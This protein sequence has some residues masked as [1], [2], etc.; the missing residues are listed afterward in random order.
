[1][2]SRPRLHGQSEGSLPLMPINRR[3]AE[4]TTSILPLAPSGC[5]SGCRV[6]LRTAW[7]SPSKRRPSWRRASRRPTTWHR[8]PRRGADARP[9]VLWPPPAGRCS[10]IAALAEV[11]TTAW[12]EDTLARVGQGAEPRLAPR[13]SQRNERLGASAPQRLGP[14]PVHPAAT[15]RQ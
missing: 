9:S 5:T 7:T 12:A 1:M 10:A 14:G 6:R 8:R 15:R 4:R 11:V 3:G 2:E 13:A